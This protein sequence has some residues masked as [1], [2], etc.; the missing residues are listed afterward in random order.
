MHKKSLFY[1]MSLLVIAS[2][3]L[4]ACAP[5]AT[6][7]SST[8]LVSAAKAEGNLTVIALPHSWC[9]YGEAIDAFKAKYGIAINE[10]N[11]DGSSGDE[12]EAIKANKDN[13]G[14]QAPDVIDVGF[15]FGPQLVSE[16]LVQPYKVSTWDTIPADVKDANGN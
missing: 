6:G 12:I 11:P 3:V 4:S 14:P 8:D 16:G 1:V 9:N 13:K 5:K 7:S 15:S 10:L 2:M